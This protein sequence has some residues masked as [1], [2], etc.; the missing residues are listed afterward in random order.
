ML[1]NGLLHLFLQPLE[2]SH[3]RYLL[4]SKHITFYTRYV[5]D[6]LIIYDASCTN[7]NVR[8]QYSNSIHR[9]LQ[10]NPTVEANDRINFLDLS[11]IRKTPPNWKLTLFVN[12]QP[13][14]PLS[15]TYPTTQVNINLQHTDT[16]LR[17]CS[18]TPSTMTDYTMSGKPPSTLQKPTNSQLPYTTN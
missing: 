6:I 15:T 17:G 13:P 3:V 5:D 8:A 14:T 10:L 16:T 1:L 12:P 7:P 11:I 9:S 4:D 18:T 2:Q